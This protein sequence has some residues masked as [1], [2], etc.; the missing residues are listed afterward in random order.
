MHKQLGLDVS[1]SAGEA[2]RPMAISL[3]LAPW[4][5]IGLNLLLRISFQDGAFQRRASSLSLSVCTLL[6]FR[7]KS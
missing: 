1:A 3:P 4:H 6:F 5:V 2:E 7:L